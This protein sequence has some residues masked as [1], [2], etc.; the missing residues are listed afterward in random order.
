MILLQCQDFQPLEAFANFRQTWLCAWRTLMA[1]VEI[2]CPYI[3]NL[4]HHKGHLDSVTK[5]QYCIPKGH[6]LAYIDWPCSGLAP[7]MTGDF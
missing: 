6:R 2:S 5:H 1:F 7:F 3:Q 4:K